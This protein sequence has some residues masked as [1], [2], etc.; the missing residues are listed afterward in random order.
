[1]TLYAE[2]GVREFRGS[3]LLFNSPAGDWEIFFQSRNSW[4][5]RLRNY[6]WPVVDVDF[7][8][9]AFFWSLFRAYRP[10]WALR[11]SCKDLHHEVRSDFQCAALDVNED[12]LTRGRTNANFSR[13]FFFSSCAR[14][15]SCKHKD[16]FSWAN[17]GFKIRMFLWPAATETCSSLPEWLHR[18]HTARNNFQTSKTPCRTFESFQSRKG[19]SAAC[20]PAG[21][22]ETRRKMLIWPMAVKN[23]F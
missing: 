23:R 5:G 20:K 2:K 18:L 15:N 19:P 17:P 6:S 9:G 10:S 11:A 3:L 14:K 12:R 13:A 22:K 16:F 4:S 1:M 21:A 8:S 7:R